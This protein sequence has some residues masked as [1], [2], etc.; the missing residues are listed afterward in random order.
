MNEQPVTTSK[1]AALGRRLAGV[2]AIAVA[3]IICAGG[4]HVTAKTAPSGLMGWKWGDDAAECARQAALTCERWYP[5]TNPAFETS[6][7]FDHPRTVLGATGLVNLVRSDGKQLEGVQVIYRGCTSDE[8][9]QR[10]LRAALRQEL[11]VSSP[12]VEVPY[13]VWED[14]SLVHFETS[15]RDDTCTLTVAGPRFGKAFA[16]ALLARGLSDVGAA[17]TPH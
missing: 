16:A 13:Q 15:K 8:V 2:A 11:H 7:D 3:T 1:R 6:M 9:H 4:C 14:D 5:W 17:M 12:D 10:E